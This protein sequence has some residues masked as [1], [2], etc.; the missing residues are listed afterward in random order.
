MQ[1]Y[2]NCSTVQLSMNDVIKNL[3][4]RC[5]YL[6]KNTISIRASIDKSYIFSPLHNVSNLNICIFL[7][8]KCSSGLCSDLFEFEYCITQQKPNSHRELQ[9]PLHYKCAYTHVQ[10]FVYVHKQNAIHD[11]KRSIIIMHLKVISS[12]SLILLFQNSVP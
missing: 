11:K 2:K 7:L 8:F 10:Q 3:T 9:A 6:I 1:V 4:N 12:V 5:H